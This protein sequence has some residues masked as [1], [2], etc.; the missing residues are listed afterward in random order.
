MVRLDK[1]CIALVCVVCSLNI[2]AD[3]LKL[4]YSRPATVWTEALPLG[5]SR[6]GVMVYGG[7]GAEELQLNEET[8]WGEGLTV[9]IILKLWLHCLKSD[10]WCLRS[11]I[12]RHRKW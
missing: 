5:N 7:T 3:D 12:G 10:S 8:V 4:W 6:L 11:V 9:M 1:I 2:S